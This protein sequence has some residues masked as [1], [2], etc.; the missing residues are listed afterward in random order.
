MPAAFKRCVQS[1]GRVRTKSLSGGRY[2]RLCYKNGKSY[3]GEVKMKKKN[4]KKS[5]KK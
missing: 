3:A 1:G 2:M 4:I 5:R